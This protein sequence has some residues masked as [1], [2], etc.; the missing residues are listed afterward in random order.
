MCYIGEKIV[1]VALFILTIT[2]KF[3]D[4]KGVINV[5]DSASV[6][7]NDFNSDVYGENLKKMDIGN[8]V[9]FQIKVAEAVAK[10]EFATIDLKSVRNV[11]SKE[12][13]SL[14]EEFLKQY[15]GKEPEWGELG[16]FTFK[17]TYARRVERE[18]G[19]SI[20]TEEW[21]EV[22][23]RVVEGNLSIIENDPLAT[24]EYAQKMY[25]LIWNLVFTPPGR[26]LWMSGTEFSKRTG[27]SSNNC[28][29]VET[30]PYHYGETNKIFTRYEIDPTAKYVSY[31][32]VFLFDQAMKGGGVGFSAEQ[33]VISEIPKVLNRT[34]IY[35]YCDKYHKDFKELKDMTKTHK[36]RLNKKVPNTAKS[37]GNP[38]IIELTVAD[39]REG[40]AESL[41]VVID[42]HFRGRHVIIKINVS[43]IRHRGLPIKGF[44]GV[45]SGPAPLVEL[46]AFVSYRL[47]TRKG[48]YL[49]SVDVG[50]IHNAIGRA[51]V[52]G[53][54]RRTAEI[55][56]GSPTDNAF[57]N[58]KN[59]LLIQHVIKKWE[60]NTP[61]LKSVK[62]L[63]KEGYSKEQAEADYYMA[64]AQGN[65][66]W[67]SNNSIVVDDPRA[68]DFGFISPAIEA[69][70]EPGILNRWLMQ[71]FGR[72]I[73]GYRKGVDGKATGGNPCCE[74][75]LESTEPCNLVE[76]MLPVAQKLGIPH[77]EILPLMVQY[78]KRVTFSNYDWESSAEVIYRNRR[79]GVS[80]SG[81]Q[82]WILMKYG[83]GAIKGWKLYNKEAWNDMLWLTD[84]QPYVFYEELPVYDPELSVVE[85]V[86]NEKLLEEIDRMYKLVVQADIEFSA[87]LT[88]HLGFE[89]LPS[90]KKTTNKPSGT[91][92]LLPFVSPGVHNHYFRYGIRRIRVQ[93]T[94]PLLKL[95]QLAGYYAE[96]VANNPSSWVIE[97]P[98]EA[99]SAKYDDFRD[100]SEVTIEEQFAMQALMC[101]YWADNMVS[102]TI[103]FH[104]EEKP[105]IKHLLE[106]YRMRIKSTS[107]LPY[108]GHG[109]K[110]AP[111]EPF[112]PINKEDGTVVTPKEQ[113]EQAMKKIMWKTHELY[114]VLMEQGDF[115]DSEMTLEEALE[116]A[117]GACPTR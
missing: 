72:I 18:D 33:H 83:R 57:I 58:Q 1:F 47:S 46:L 99:P 75:S 31:P 110:Q 32:F 59:Y 13:F 90:I 50:D 94:D 93:Y 117:G 61:V 107:L 100:A 40:W 91:V 111:Y 64:W 22:V 103:T 67:A 74:I 116:C 49:T 105:K 15:E 17:R 24:P 23:R 80:L 112:L 89:V 44:G 88:K 38:I 101:V 76:Y 73:D 60:G 70:G 113:Y 28:W 7:Y 51:V 2:L 86:Y 66:R 77:E 87:V 68:Y 41:A 4:S 30:R 35:F 34:D 42:N 36:I 39:A 11:L 3:T 84:D 102:C 12:V 97:F 95:A 81:V 92:A 8:I 43:E 52:A 71:N 55:N 85:P 53:N 54:V 106:Q 16:W 108:S 9:P 104:N 62:E 20:R 98:V 65:H 5:S 69:N 45:A 63:M 6:A 56:F 82:D 27:D 48:Q 79:F 96:P 37:S 26:G 109:F 25:H 21:T 78:A 10:N 115:Q 19:S 14:D 114:H 29:F